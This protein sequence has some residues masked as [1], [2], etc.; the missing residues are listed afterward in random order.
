MLKDMQGLGYAE[1]ARILNIP[2][3]TV[4]SRVYYARRA[5]RE[6]LESMGVSYP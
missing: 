5:L 4:A 1:I 6:A 3:G 2:Q